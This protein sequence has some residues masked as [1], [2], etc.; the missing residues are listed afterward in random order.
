MIT[1]TYDMEIV[2][3]ILTHPDIWSDIS[4][5]GVEPFDIPYHAECLYFLFNDMSG[6]IIFHPFLDGMKI[7][8]NIIAKERGKL[9]YEAV[10][11]SIQVVLKD[12]Q[13][14]YAEIDVELKHVIRF[15]K[16]LGF[17][18]IES[19]DRE[20]FVRHKLDS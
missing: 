6:V 20:L 15:A 12:Y 17:K 2:N 13:S 4:P 14:V 16:T 11:A 1:E 7:H 19:S 5:T 9:A 18:W 3:S 8:P 10:E